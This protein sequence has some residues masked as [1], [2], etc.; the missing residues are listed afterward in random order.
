RVGGR[1]LLGVLDLDPILSQT[2]DG[3]LDILN[4]EP[5]ELETRG[6]PGP[7]LQQLDE[8]I[9]ARLEQG[10]ERLPVLALPRVDLAQSEVLRVE[11][12]ALL[13]IVDGDRD[14][15]HAEGSVF[16]SRGAL[17]RRA[18]HE[19][20]C[21][22]YEKRAHLMPPCRNQRSSWFECPGERPSEPSHCRA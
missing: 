22:K 14:V 3:R 8:G 16:L 12:L 13:K 17:K 11:V 1:R 10:H 18:A 15:I 19:H 20:A 9:A 5:E 7:R 4:A 2:R 6:A 21:E